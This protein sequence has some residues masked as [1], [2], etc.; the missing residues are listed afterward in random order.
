LNAKRHQH[1]WNHCRS[2]QTDRPCDE[3]WEFDLQTVDQQCGRH[4]DQGWRF[5]NSKGCAPGA[6]AVPVCCRHSNDE[7]NAGNRQKVDGAGD[8]RLIAAGKAELNDRNAKVANIAKNGDQHIRS[9]HFRRAPQRSCD[10]IA[11]SRTTQVNDNRIC[12]HLPGKGCA[13]AGAA[14]D[15]EGERGNKNKVRETG[16]RPRFK[17]ETRT[18]DVTKGHQQEHRREHVEED[19]QQSRHIALHT[20]DRANTDQHRS[21]DSESAERCSNRRS[22]ARRKGFRS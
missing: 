22:M 14:H 13:N 16:Q 2:K 3:G 19:R 12:H 8:Q 10:Q 15:V 18:G 11:H 7:G 5:D 4:C 6:A 1:G 21:A 20:T 9:H 17:V